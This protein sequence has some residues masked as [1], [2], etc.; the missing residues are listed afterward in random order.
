MKRP[1]LEWIRDTPHDFGR[2]DGIYD[3]LMDWRELDLSN[4]GLTDSDLALLQGWTSKTLRCLR[5]QGNKL[6]HL[7]AW[8]GNTQHFPQLE[9]L[10]IGKNPLLQGQTEVAKA[11]KAGTDWITG[12]EDG[13]AALDVLQWPHKIDEK[14]TVPRTTLQLVTVGNYEVGKSTVL[15]NGWLS[16]TFIS[17]GPVTELERTRGVLLFP[18]R[19]EEANIDWLVRDLPG[20]PEFYATNIHFLTADSAVFMVVCKL[21]DVKKRCRTSRDTRVEQLRTWL[22]TL[23]ALAHEKMDIRSIVVC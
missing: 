1:L 10:F 18:H 11:V 22:G 2:I 5:L 23:H 7:P 15:W 13:I 14:K 21:Y 17:S 16:K 6:T 19:D 9:R 20:Q 3:N 8:L 12:R 4:T